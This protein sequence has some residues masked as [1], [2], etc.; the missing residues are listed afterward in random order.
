MQPE[1]AFDVI[2]SIYFT[3]PNLKG[4]LIGLVAITGFRCNCFKTN[5]QKRGIR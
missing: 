3:A 4:N 5:P 2:Q 1:T